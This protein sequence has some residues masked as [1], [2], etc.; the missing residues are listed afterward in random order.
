MLD[1]TDRKLLELLQRN[2]RATSLELGEALHLSPSQA[3]R[4][5]QR[6]EAEG[7]ILGEA[8]RVDPEKLGLGVQAFVQVTMAAHTNETA[9]AFL[10][11]VE[12]QPEITSMWTLTG[13]A[14]YLLRVY[15]RSLNDLNELVH[16]ILL[17][18]PSVARLQS[19]IVMNQI[20]PDSPLP[21]IG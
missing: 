21:V 14:D 5:R 15:C 4:R 3:G 17:P 11:L 16:E 10:R 6:L 1:Q 7:Y 8:A 13:D 12:M 2:S 18:H 9:K 19:Q 20:K